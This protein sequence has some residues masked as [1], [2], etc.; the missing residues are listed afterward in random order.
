MK[1][2]IINA[3]DF[4][5]TRII[6][7]KIIKIFKIGNLSST[8][9]IVNTPACDYAIDLAKN[10]P[11]LG[12]GL[13]FN[14]T[15][16]SSLSGVSSLTDLKGLFFNKL[17][18]NFSVALRLV[19]LKDIENELIKQ[20][21]YMINSGL[22]PS[23]IDSHQH[24]HMNPS[25]FKIVADFAKE[26]NVPIRIAFPQVIKRSRGNINYKKRIKQ[27][28]LQYASFK[29]SKYAR[30][31]GI[32]FNKSFNSIFDFHPFKM[33]EK[34]DYINLINKSYSNNH[35]LMIHLYE[36]SEELKEFYGQSY[37]S[38]IAFFKKANQEMNILSKEPI[39]D[40]YK[41]VT[42]KDL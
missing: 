1:K 2:L 16:G 39:F 38:K 31:I 24:I 20:F 35:E 8:S 40:N 26:K 37:S 13:H 7:D 29:N 27:L 17:R 30:K 6:S 18:L 23:H 9:L 41:L 10:H 15:E 19:H 11:R 3:D 32:K 28:I 22:V 14:I 5:L 12:V 36:E 21:D 4:G 25:V 34:I 42:F 33:P